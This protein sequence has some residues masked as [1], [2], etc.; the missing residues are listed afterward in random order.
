MAPY[1]DFTEDTVFHGDTMRFLS[2]QETT[3]GERPGK[4]RVLEPVVLTRA[5]TGKNACAPPIYSGPS[6]AMDYKGELACPVQPLLLAAGMTSYAGAFFT[7]RVPHII[8]SHPYLHIHPLNVPTETDIGDRRFCVVLIELAY[9]HPPTQALGTLI[10]SHPI[11]YLHTHPLNVPSEKDIGDRRFCVVLIELAYIH[12]P[13]QAWGSLF[14]SHPILYLLT[15]PL[16]VPTTKDIGDRRF[17]VVLIELAYIH[18]PSQA[19]GSLIPSHPILYLLTHPL[20]VPTTKDIGDRRF[21]VV[22]T[23]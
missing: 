8:P 7:L 13:T 11:L 12:P 3:Y 10:P 2:V 6:L 14:P 22:L 23:H 4:A 16:N 17:C 1:K 9:I 20:N 18:P 21:R 15:H 5:Q 19:F